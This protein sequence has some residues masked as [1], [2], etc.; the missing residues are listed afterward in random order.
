[1]ILDGDDEFQNIELQI[2][3]AGRLRVLSA[4]DDFHESVGASTAQ[5]S[6]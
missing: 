3:G 5:K 1:M 2:D 6:S 4:P